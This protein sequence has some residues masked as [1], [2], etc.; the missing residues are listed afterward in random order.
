MIGDILVGIAGSPVIDPD[1]L[2]GRLAG[3]VVGKPTQVEI[4]RGG[5][6]ATVTVTVGERK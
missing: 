1:D 6:P 3:S 5:Q 2:L 4:L